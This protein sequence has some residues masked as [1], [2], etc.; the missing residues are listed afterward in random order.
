MV[1][2]I[3][4]DRLE[5]VYTYDHPSKIFGSHKMHMVKDLMKFSKYGDAKAGSKPF[6]FFF[7]GGA[8]K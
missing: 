2:K 5:R 3:V 7:G 8:C 1:S 4:M 6:L